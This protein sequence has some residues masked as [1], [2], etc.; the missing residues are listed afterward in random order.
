MQKAVILA[1]CDTTQ[2]IDILEDAV[3]A[4]R[5]EFWT[6]AC[7]SKST[8]PATLASRPFLWNSREDASTSVGVAPIALSKAIGF[9]KPST[10]SG[11]NCPAV[12]G[13]RSFPSIPLTANVWNCTGF[14]VPATFN[15]AD[16]VS[17][18]VSRVPDIGTSDI[19]PDKF[20]SAFGF[21]VPAS[22][23]DLDGVHGPTD[24]DDVLPAFS[25]SNLVTEI[26]SHLIFNT[27]VN[28][29][30]YQDLQRAQFPTGHP[31]FNDCNPTGAAYGLIALRSSNAN[32]EKCLPSLT[33]SEIRSILAKGGAVRSSKDF[34]AE[35]TYGSGVYAELDATLNGTT[36]NAIQICRRVNGSGTQAQANAMILGY[37]CDATFDSAIDTLVPEAESAL[38]TFVTEN[39][40]SANLEKCLNDFNNGTN[41]TG[42]N[43]VPAGCVYPNCRKRW[44]IGVQSLEKNNTLTNSYRFIKID[45]FAPTLANVHAGDYYDVA[46]QTMQ[47]KSGA[48][49]VTVDAFYALKPYVRDPFSLSEINKYH[50]FGISGW[51]ATPYTL[52]TPDS[53]LYL[54]RPVA[55]FRRVSSSGVANTCTFP[56]AFRKSGVPG[57]D[58]TVG[59]TN[60]SAGANTDGDQNCYTP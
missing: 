50:A 47:F 53:K 24:P 60:C 17:D 32:K 31:L 8:L 34:Q 35:T 15:E 51:L 14:A 29:L 52:L 3:I 41:T 56:S 38:T 22:D 39:W 37:P 58:I 6:V 46:Q 45:G 25:A 49:A 55:W 43:N 27:P 23:F 16:P 33:A 1:F 20:T 2:P 4:G 57:I 10:G 21:N 28:L 19:E 30:M 40:S 48:P 44:A 54:S 13:S 7:I 59:P 12:T 9:M 42:K 26:V 5:P 11:T 36:D 18:G